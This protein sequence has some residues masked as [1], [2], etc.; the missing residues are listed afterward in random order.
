MYLIAW[1]P[2]GLEVQG[3]KIFNSWI[4]QW[5]QQLHHRVRKSTI[6]TLWTLIDVVRERCA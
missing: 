4:Q 6:F 2:L 5:R 3:I 1:A